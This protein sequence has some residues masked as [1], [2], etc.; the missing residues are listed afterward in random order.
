[1]G[2]ELPCQLV[3]SEVDNDTI[4]ILVDYS[5]IEVVVAVDEERDIFT[6]LYDEGSH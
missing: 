1:M 6:N 4:F 2:R 3:T 5:D